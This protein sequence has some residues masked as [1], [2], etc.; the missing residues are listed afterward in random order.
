MPPSARDERRLPA[1]E[2]LHN[3][4]ELNESDQAVSSSA[5]NREPSEDLEDHEQSRTESTSPSSSNTPSEDA[6][7]CPGSPS[8]D[9]NAEESTV[10]TPGPR[11]TSDWFAW[12]LGGVVASAGLLAAM[13]V[14]LG[15]CDQQPQPTWPHISLNAVISVLSTLSKASLV[16]SVGESLGQ[17]KWVWF[18][19]QERPLL[20]LQSFDRASRGA[21]GS[22]GLVW[23]QRAR[24]FAGLG[25]LVMI[26]A[27]GFDPFSQNLI[28]SSVRMVVDPF[29][30]ARIGTVSRYNTFGYATSARD[31]DIDPVMKGNVYNALFNNDQS[32]PWAI[33]QFV[34]TSSNCT[35][36]KP[37]TSLEFRTLCSNV[38]SALVTNCTTVPNQSFSNCTLTLPKSNTSVWY[39]PDSNVMTPF[40]V[41][42]T[43]PPYAEVY[44]NSSLIVIQYIAPRG[45]NLTLLTAGI[46]PNGS[47]WDATECVLD[48]IV[49]SFLPAVHEN[50]Y[51]EETLAVWT[52]T[53]VSTNRII[54]PGN[55]FIPDYWATLTPPDSWVTNYGAPANRSS[56]QDN[57]AQPFVLGIQAAYTIVTFLQDILSG[58]SIRGAIHTVFSP[59]AAYSRYA[60]QDTVQA[61]GT[62]NITGC[63]NLLAERLPCAME[64]VAA[65]MTKTLRDSA[66]IADAISTSDWAMGRAMIPAVYV[67]VHWQWMVL[68]LLVWVVGA[69]LVGGT[70]WKTRRARVPAWRNNPLPLLFLYRGGERHTP[71]EKMPLWLQYGSPAEPGSE[72]GMARLYEDDGRVLL[73][74]WT[75]NNTQDDDKR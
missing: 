9:D 7:S 70:L 19:Q 1:Y 8:A 21:W 40:S 35:W 32:R 5:V 27:V 44:T 16:F 54:I 10:N 48:P 31:E 33:P 36:D 30:T 61:L 62:G 13:L 57:S 15:V 4:L 22:L 11:E 50:K 39:L 12:E 53:N 60:S 74:R 55:L 63:S 26:F 68:P 66:Y 38:T 14:L 2:P 72:L 49:R 59:A 41:A 67:T 18:N 24:H 69:T 51:S 23:T 47:G 58:Q 29:G 17:L 3:E 42:A 6:A 64:N 65:A 20:D 73:G 28:H 37:V 25:A 56:P 43:D 45:A 52:Q 75:K 34:C 71:D 46:L